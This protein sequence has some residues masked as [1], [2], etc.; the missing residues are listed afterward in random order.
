MRE[1]LDKL[2]FDIVANSPDQFAA[3]IKA[4]ME[5]WAKVIRDAKI[6]VEGAQ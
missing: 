5:K 3:Q 6:K 1:R 4:E 2:G